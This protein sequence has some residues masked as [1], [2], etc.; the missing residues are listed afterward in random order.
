MNKTVISQFINYYTT[1][2]ETTEY[3]ERVEQF[4]VVDL[5]NQII[6]ETLKNKPLTNEH[7]TGLIQMF[8]YGCSDETFDKYLKQNVTDKTRHNQLHDLAYKIND[9][10][11]TG[12]GLT[13]V[14]GLTNAQLEEVRSFLLKAFD[15]KTVDEAVTLC[16]NFDAKDIPLV[17]SGIYSPWLYYINPKLFPILN[18]SHKKFREWLE[19]PSEYPACIKPFNE[20]KDLVN[21]SELGVIDRFAYDFPDSISGQRT[22]NLNGKKL[23]KVSHGVF[24]KTTEY[25]K[26][27]IASVLEE[28]NWIC[29]HGS[30][31]K[32][33]G[34]SFENSANIGD[35]VYVC[36]G[37]DEL[38]CVA[39]LVSVAKP[40]DSATDQLIDGVGGWVY[41]EIEPLF[42]P[43]DSSTRDLKDDTRF[44]MPSG[45]STFYEI[46]KSGITI[47]NSKIFIPKFNLKIIDDDSTV[48]SNSDIN[49][50]TKKNMALNTILYGPPGTGKTFNSISIAVELAL[51]KKFN[52]HPEYKV[53]FDKLRKTGQIEF[54]TFHQNYSYEDFVLGL[55]PNL[56]VG[57]TGL[58]F[59]LVPGVFMRICNAAKENYIQSKL[60]GDVK[61][62]FKE[63][64]EEF[65]NPLLLGQVKEIE[66][67]T[68]AGT[69]PFWL[70]AAN[71]YN[72]SFRKNSG[73]EGHTLS[74]DTLKD[75]YNETRTYESGLSIYYQGILNVL[76]EKGKIQGG[77]K[78][79]EK[80][81]V[82][83]IDEINRANMSKVF[84][85][86]ITLLEDDKRIG[87][88]N[89]LSITIPNTDIKLTLP[90]NLY[91]LGTMNTADKS[92]ALV[93][94]ALRR[95]FEF[96]G[97][98]PTTDLLSKLKTE[99]LIT[100]KAEKIL[101]HLNKK[102]YSEKNNNADFLIGHAYFINKKDSDL[103]IVLRNKIVPLL[104]E[105]FSGRSERV[106]ELFKGSD[107]SV[108]YDSNNFDWV[109]N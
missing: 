95:R 101:S 31:G 61:R 73:G 85:E 103:P 25:R 45:N 66:L 39:K 90:P 14:R 26:S 62:P 78:I 104:M 91:I 54:V 67:K 98:Y 12:A 22:L 34:D 96:K 105:Y 79:E 107:F 99:K 86:L 20:L 8:K 50:S 76:Y 2:K 84:G 7:L 47:V 16:Q 35:Y 44:Y 93:D 27:G 80:N 68:E 5:H 53:E 82:L 52:T 60:G 72:F 17:T 37:G 23:F 10:G 94:I 57:Q 81:Y 106:I 3:K 71:E 75:L 100:E 87:E 88:E 48:S 24:K 15:V 55:K 83:V 13:A 59:S 108:S 28:N 29:L 42:F 41:R 33:Q 40:L 63:V 92:I 18:N 89:E 46:P 21:E 74:Y 36:Y 4:A 58:T 56:N 38:Y 19:L 1:F 70:T 32:N 6:T 65:R 49:N 69:T 97:Y 11:Y 51:K 43:V 109:I 9:Y 30:T 64:F 77:K 102:V